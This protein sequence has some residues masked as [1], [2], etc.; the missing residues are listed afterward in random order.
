LIKLNLKVLSRS[1]INQ[2]TISYTIGKL[3]LYMRDIGKPRG[4]S[5]GRG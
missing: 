4:W 5:Q 2:K 1:R 3:A